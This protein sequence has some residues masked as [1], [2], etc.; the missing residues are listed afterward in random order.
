M[1]APLFLILTLVAVTLLAT[2]AAP[3][4]NHSPRLR[5]RQP[6][7]R[8]GRLATTTLLARKGKLGKALSGL[9]APSS[10]SVPLRAK[11]KERDALRSKEK[12]LVDSIL[13][14]VSPTTNRDLPAITAKIGELRSLQV[15]S[16]RVLAGGKKSLDYGLVFAWD[17][18]AVSYVGTGLHKVP[19][20]RLD[21]MFLTLGKARV[22]V[23]EVI[24]IIGPFPNVLNTLSGEARVESSDVITFTIDSVV[25]GTGKELVGE[26]PRVVTPKVLYASEAAIIFDTADGKESAPKYLI[27]VREEDVEG[28]LYEKNLGEDRKNRV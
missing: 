12:A 3:Y 25:D 19:L 13:A 20:A 7:G 16:L 4:C 21:Y 28:L 5:S 2:P 27:F 14:L 1:G 9:D 6:R 17:D 24:R 10:P 11:Q 8:L 23:R 22:L 15:D 26:E 18:D